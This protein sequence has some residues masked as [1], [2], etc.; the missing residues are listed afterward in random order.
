VIAEAALIV[1]VAGVAGSGKT[2][3]GATL[4]E[5]LHAEFADADTFHPAA[6][7]AKMRA[8]QP[9]TDAD[10]EPWLRAIGDWMDERIAAGQRA[11]ITC[12]ALRRG[13][14]D[15][16]LLGRPAAR[17]VFLA[18]RPQVA[19]A[20]LAGRPGH[21]FP[22]RLLDSQFAMLEPP[23]PAERVLVVDADQP[24]DVL[25]ASIAAGLRQPGGRNVTG[26]TRP[27]R[28]EAP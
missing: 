28:P 8:G 22:G 6:N 27:A 19:A 10:R 21:F 11:V 5:R 13:Y 24:L 15:R 23:D 26:D 7:V 12:S 20:R 9:L 4:A 25:I 3:V 2:T 17:M 16:L 14:R 1:V 18:L